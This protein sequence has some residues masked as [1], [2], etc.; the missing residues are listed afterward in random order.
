MEA[1]APQ[2]VWRE[3]EVGC[4]GWLL[5]PRAARPVCMG[6]AQ[7]RR[8]PDARRCSVKQPPLS[9]HS[10]RMYVLSFICVSKE[11]VACVRFARQT[12]HRSMTSRVAGLSCGKSSICLFFHMISSQVSELVHSFTKCFIKS[13]ARY[14]CAL[15]YQMVLI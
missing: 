7:C 4:S 3:V 12:K 9:G 1:K 2:E 6:L 10:A 14:C 8:A 11:P 15:W 5:V 13:D